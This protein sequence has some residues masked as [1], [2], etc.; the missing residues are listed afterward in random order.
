VQLKDAVWFIIDCI[1]P[2]AQPLSK[3]E[4]QK[5]EEKPREEAE[6]CKKRIAELSEDEKVLNEYLSECAK[7]LEGEDA[8][9]QSVETRL[10]S[11]MGLSSIAG[12][13]VFG[14]L[15]AQATGVLQVQRGW[16]RWM[17]TLGGLYLVMQLCSAILAALSGLLARQAYLATE[18]RD[19][20]PSP[21]GEA[22]PIYLRRRIRESVAE[23]EDHELLNNKKV[24]QMAVAHRAMKNFLWVLLFI[25]LIGAYGSI[26]QSSRAD[27]LFERLR[28][29]HEVQEL[30]R[31]P[32]GVPGPRG[33][34]CIGL[35]EPPPRKQHT[36]KQ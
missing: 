13:I 20:F 10:T 1:F 14:G 7:L 11:I 29:D 23:L 34:P 31:G 33:E 35:P 3:I 32:Q 8:R 26:T 30:L 21:G 17:M 15:L 24:T 5:Q 12:T 36:G 18:T 4:S 6:E 9:R 19:I 22:R 16:L 28:K 25:A 27:D 2:L